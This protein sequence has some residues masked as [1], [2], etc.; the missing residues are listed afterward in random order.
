MILKTLQRRGV[1]V[2]MVS[3]DVEFCAEYADRCALFFDG[4]IVSEGRPRQFFSGNSFY[5]TS[6]NRMARSLL[7]EA[8]TPRDIMAACGGTL[9]QEPELP[10]EVPPLPEP[11]GSQLPI[12]GEYYNVGDETNDSEDDSSET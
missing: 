6:A 7:P 11:V 2:F 4:N 3:H 12:R 5:T 8:V 1:T 10:E 9:S